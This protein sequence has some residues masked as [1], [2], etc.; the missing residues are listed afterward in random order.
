MLYAAAAAAASRRGATPGRRGLGAPT[1]RVQLH[2]PCRAVIVLRLLL[3]VL[4]P[5][6]GLCTGGAACAQADPAPAPISADAER[7]ARAIADFEA[8]RDKP[9]DDALRRRT[10]HWLGEVDHPAVTEYLRTELERTPLRAAAPVLE[11]IGAVP[12]PVLQPAVWNALLTAPSERVRRAAAATVARVGERG[13]D[14][15]LEF[16]RDDTDEAGAG[17][18]RDA[19]VRALIEHGGDR[20]RRGLAPL[21]AEGPMEGRHTLL[22][23]LEGVRGVGAIRRARI[24]LVAD[25]DLATAALAWRQLAEE[26]PARA[27]ALAIDVLERCLELPPPAVA[28]DLVRGLVLVQDRDLYPALLRFGAVPGAAVRSAL[29]DSAAAAAA[30][31]ALIDWL[32]RTGIDSETPA[33]REIARLL[34]R[35]APGDAVGPLLERVRKELRSAS[36]ASLDRAVALH[37]LLARDP[38]WRSDLRTLAESPRPDV[39]VVGLSLLHDLGSD[40]ALLSAQKSLDHKSWELRSVSLRYLTRCRAVTSIPLLIDRVERESGRLAHELATALFAHTGTRCFSRREWQKWWAEHKV[41]FALPPIEAVRGGVES[42]AGVTVAYHGIP[43]VSERMTFLVDV[44][45]SMRE[46]LGTDDRRTRLDG[47]KAELA[48]VFAALPDDHRCNLIAY[49]S[50]VLPLWDGLRPAGPH[51]TTLLETAAKLPYGRATNLFDAL[52]RA[53][54][55]PDVDTIYLLSDGEP[56]NGRLVAP[57]EILDEVRRWNLQRQIVIHCIGLGIDSRLLRELA[58]DSGG[59]YRVVR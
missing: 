25:G 47:A 18:A 9:A 50:E 4:L 15:L 39:R 8:C 48:K 41:G 5:C 59:D 22:R 3:L 11:A 53:F 30:D 19:A 20:A 43:L 31:R 37:P 16:V 1:P 2:G 56:T 21:L 54:A 36:K 7:A 55:D 42:N 10:L 35:E 44:S 12:R 28:A 32:I 40:V 34:L 17:R 52:E 51:R 24:D 27:K 58:A 26:D 23:R 46:R 57:D 29:R 49:E 13:I 38:S 33:T 6:V 14:R 45:G